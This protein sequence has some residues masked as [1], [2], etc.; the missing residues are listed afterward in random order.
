MSLSTKNCQ[1]DLLTAQLDKVEL[2]ERK[3]KVEAIASTK[4]SQQEPPTLNTLSTE[5]HRAL[6]K[7][8][9]PVTSCCHGLTCKAFYDIHWSNHGLVRLYA[10]RTYPW[11]GYESPPEEYDGLWKLLRGWFPADLNFKWTTGRYVC[12]EEYTEFLNTNLGLRKPW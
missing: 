5:L 1:R 12:E 7:F 9:N 3:E 11:M 2:D 10:P 6:F 4:G 8:L